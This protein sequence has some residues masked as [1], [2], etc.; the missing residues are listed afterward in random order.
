MPQAVSVVVVASG[1]LYLSKLG[2]A[3]SETTELPKS[4][5]VFLVVVAGIAL[6][7]SFMGCWGA[8]RESPCL[9]SSFAVF[10]LLLLVAELVVAALVT[11][12][13]G[14]FESLAADGMLKALHER[15]DTGYNA[16]DDIQTQLKCC[17]VRGIS[18]YNTTKLPDSCC[19]PT[20][21][22]EQEHHCTSDQAYPQACLPVLRDELS[23][24]WHTVA[25]AGIIVALIQLG[26][27]IGSC[28]LARA[29]R[30][31]YDVV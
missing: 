8:V 31:E 29:F 27:V 13:S 25:A 23:P 6:V 2:S 10:I 20:G 16:I 9:L 4:S 22:P 19:P 1:L 30:R 26:A 7:I 17:G 28:C 5:V 12:Y 21:P 15:R 11:K 24:F 3:L 18:D 14:E